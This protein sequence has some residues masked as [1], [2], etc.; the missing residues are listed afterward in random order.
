[1]QQLCYF[2][3]GREIYPTKAFVI[4][5][6]AFIADSIDQG[7]EIVLSLDGNENMRTGNITKSLLKLRMIEISQLFSIEK[8]PPTFI[9]GSNQLDAV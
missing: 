8:V 3:I 7:F 5:I 6:A 4:D 1:M 2:K 9:T